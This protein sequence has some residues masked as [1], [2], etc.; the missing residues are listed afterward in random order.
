M[1][2]KSRRRTPGTRRGV[3]CWLERQT[4]HTQRD[5]VDFH[6]DSAMAVQVVGRFVVDLTARPHEGRGRS[7]QVAA[8]SVSSR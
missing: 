8:A 4:Q 2:R 6:A 1:I 5:P 3:D 7:R